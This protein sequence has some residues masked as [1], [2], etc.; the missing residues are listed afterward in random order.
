MAIV[1]ID[2]NDK[3]PR[4]YWPEDLRHYGYSGEVELIC[5]PFT[6]T[7]LHPNATPEQIIG[8]LENRIRDIQLRKASAKR[9]EFRPLQE[10]AAK[11]SP[12]K[13]PEAEWES[14]QCPYPDC[15]A[16]LMWNVN[17]DQ[18]ACSRCGRPIVRYGIQSS[19]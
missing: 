11:T 9:S 18:A 10:P 5:D 4:I 1:K 13:A 6:A 17:W 2:P 14:M 15:G 12:F 19:K 8:S 16:P 3:Y 7:I